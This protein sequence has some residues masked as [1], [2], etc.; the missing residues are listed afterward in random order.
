[1]TL[2][3]YLWQER[4]G[5]GKSTR[6]R[7]GEGI[8]PRREQYDAEFEAIHC[9]Q[10]KHH[11]H[12]SDKNW[13][14]FFD[15][16]FFQRPLREQEV[17]YCQVYF[18]QKE[19]RAA[20][21]LPCF[22]KFRIAQ[23]IVN[24]QII[25]ADRSSRRCLELLERKMLAEALQTQKT[26]SF[27]KVRKLLKLHEGEVFNLES[28]RREK[29]EGNETAALLSD[30]KYFG[31]TW[32][33]FSDDEQ[34]TITL[35]LLDAENTEEVLQKARQEWQVSEEQANDLATLTPENFPKGYARFG[36]RALHELTEK[37]TEQGI[38]TT[39]AIQEL[40]GNR[41]DNSERQDRLPYYGEVMP[42]SRFR[43]PSAEMMTRNNT[44]RS[45]IRPCISD[46]T[47]YAN[48]SMN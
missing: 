21:A 5:K 39:E 34:N 28:E 7:A 15:I 48:S 33:D 30:K 47:K 18:E 1:M 40:R 10:A 11:P 46:L 14:E 44:E 36:A 16:L 31:K 13:K 43:H 4:L 24:L 42:E 29:L 9:A 12:L 37:L 3:Q 26:M 41:G 25:S 8:Y 45:T 27:S 6:A 22:Q 19:R 35:F 38:S 2:G 23:N 32:F 17:G 20:K